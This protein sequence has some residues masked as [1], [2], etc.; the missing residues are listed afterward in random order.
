M[1]VKI[2]IMKIVQDSFWA[3]DVINCQNEGKRR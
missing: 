2:T 1:E 3:R